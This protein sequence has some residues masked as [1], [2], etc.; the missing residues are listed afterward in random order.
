MSYKEKLEYKMFR[1]KFGI[2]KSRK[3]HSSRNKWRASDLEKRTA[4]E[5]EI[6]G[7]IE[8]I[9]PKNLYFDKH[10]LLNYF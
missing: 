1:M 5:Y 7:Y 3:L 8:E 6:K 2:P 4:F 9:D 10:D